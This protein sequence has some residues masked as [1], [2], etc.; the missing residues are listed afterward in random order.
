MKT[1]PR[2]GET[3]T[4][5]GVFPSTSFVLEEPSILVIDPRRR[6]RE[7]LL[8]RLNGLFAEGARFLSAASVEEAA[9][10]LGR[11][12]VD[13]ILVSQRTKD[14]VAALGSLAHGKEGIPIPVVLVVED[15]TDTVATRALDAGAFDLVSSAE[16]DGPGLYRATRNAIE[17]VRMRRIL[18]EQRQVLASGAAGSGHDPVTELPERIQFCQQLSRALSRDG[19]AGTTGVLL[20]G[21]DEFKAI[22]SS[23]G[24]GM[25]DELL[26]VVA[27]RLRHCVRNVDTIARWGGDEFAALLQEMSRPEDAVFVAKRILYALS[28]PF[29]HKGQDIY[30]T[31][32]VGIAFV[33]EAGEDVEAL[34]QHADA[35]M[36]RVKGLGGNNYQVYS[37]QMNVSLTDRLET[38]NRLRR[39]LKQEEFI[40]FYQP[41]LDVHSGRVVG[42]EALLRWKDS[43]E[44]LRSPAEFI[45][46]LEETGLIVP[47]GDWVLRKACTQ[48]RAWQYAGL[49]D[50][51]VA[52]NLS[53]KQFRQQDLSKRVATILR[54][55]GLE[56]GSLELELTETVLMDDQQRSSK[57][58]SEL[59]D[60]GSLIALDDFGTGYSS[61]GF[62]K[63][64]PVD[65]LKIDRTF[66][67]DIGAVEEDRAICSAI[68]S[69]GQ[70]LKLHVMAEGVE[71]EEQ[72]EILRGQGCHLIQ[73][74][75]FAKPMPPDDVWDWLTEKSEVRP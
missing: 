62:L 2:R 60:M 48:A 5:P 27:G 32:S 38:A 58:L 40:L 15:V 44:E 21:L 52:V 54:E 24:H 42:L 49:S 67:R 75:L 51:R 9:G 22:N 73:G 8:R 66:I 7:K 14:S 53:P 18:E 13:C 46:I 37:P 12:A 6:D 56:P 47:V 23:F 34:L 70:A 1:D 68:V 35:A 10:I 74:F 25:G 20:I 55:T 16:G 50:L 26:R 36:Y 41:Q 29:V 43:A 17:A 63:A 57:I 64:F 39:A 31:A 61:L 19:A 28:R 3:A 71:T 45:P 65:T 30:L 4:K 33:P 72:M 11:E 59:K 69:L